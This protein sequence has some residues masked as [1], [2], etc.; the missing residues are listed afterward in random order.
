MGFQ[1]PTCG[2]CSHKHYNFQKCEDAAKQRKQPEYERPPSTPPGFR[3]WG[4]R[5][6][7]VD[8]VAGTL[9]QKEKHNFRT[10]TPIHFPDEVA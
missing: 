3:D 7:S 9:W 6:D 4:D 1:T 10:G 2:K 8:N 5:L